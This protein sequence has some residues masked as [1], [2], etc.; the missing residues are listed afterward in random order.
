MNVTVIDLT[1]AQAP[2]PATLVPGLHNI[3]PL[4]GDIPQSV[5]SLQDGDMRVVPSE[6]IRFEEESA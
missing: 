6:W 5:V 2:F 3:N 1:G 4:H